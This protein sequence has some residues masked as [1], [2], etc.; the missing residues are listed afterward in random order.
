VSFEPLTFGVLGEY[1][2]TYAG[3]LIPALKIVA[4]VKI[5]AVGT[6]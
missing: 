5:M 3:I 1:N 4:I 2:D 6:Y